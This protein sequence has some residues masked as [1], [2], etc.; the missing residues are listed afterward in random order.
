MAIITP[1]QEE[2]TPS[3]QMGGIKGRST[4]ENLMSAMLIMKNLACRDSRAL[5]LPVD[6]KKCFNKLHL[7][8]LLY[9]AALTDADLRAIKSLKLFHE[10][11]SIRMAEDMGKENPK[12]RV[13]PNTAGQGTNA[14]PGF[15]RNSQTQTLLKNVDY[16]LCV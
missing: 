13:I 16:E 11:F 7:S 1:C 14:A 6:M 4:Q 12:S 3:F 2:A 8:D 15:A 9:D 10:N 5:F